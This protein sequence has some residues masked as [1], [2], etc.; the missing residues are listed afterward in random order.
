LIA[1]LDGKI[2][3]FLAEG[4]S[5]AAAWIPG[6]AALAGEDQKERASSLP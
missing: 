3:G 5:R 2:N 1:S 6:R 4:D